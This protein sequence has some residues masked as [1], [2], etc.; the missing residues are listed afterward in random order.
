M[1]KDLFLFFYFERVYHGD[2]NNMRFINDWPLFLENVEG[3]KRMGH[4]TSMSMGGVLC[5]VRR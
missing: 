4:T 5:V 1:I 2:K 3:L